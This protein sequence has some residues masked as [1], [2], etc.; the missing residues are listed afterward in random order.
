MSLTGTKVGEPVMSIDFNERSI[1][2]AE[3]LHVAIWSRNGRISENFGLGYAQGLFDAE[4]IDETELASYV[5]AIS[6]GSLAHNLDFPGNDLCNRLSMISFD[7]A[8]DDTDVS[9]M[10][11]ALSDAVA[12][13]R[14][15]EFKKIWLQPREG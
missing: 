10:M 6:S 9:D 3:D 8:T 4:I 13:G 1:K 14:V 12:H 15:E 11:A 2:T 5:A 7:L